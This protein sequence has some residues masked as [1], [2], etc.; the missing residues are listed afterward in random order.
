MQFPAL[1]LFLRPCWMFRQGRPVRKAP[2]CRAHMTVL[3]CASVVRVL[4]RYLQVRGSHAPWDG[5]AGGQSAAVGHASSHEL[6]LLGSLAG[7]LIFAWDSWWAW[8]AHD[9]HQLLSL[10]LPFRGARWKKC[11]DRALI[12]RT[13]R[14]FYFQQQWHRVCSMTLHHRKW[15][16]SVAWRFERNINLTPRSSLTPSHTAKGPLELAAAASSRPFLRG[17]AA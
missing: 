4:M 3:A 7:C 14:V 1:L 17:R 12:A 11:P 13:G 9:A 6:A 15:K 5:N 16:L 2:S 8:F 10:R